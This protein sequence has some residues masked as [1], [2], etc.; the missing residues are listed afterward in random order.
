MEE[1]EMKMAS[2]PWP[3][4]KRPNID[5]VTEQLATGGDLHEE[6]SVAR[7]DV[8][9]LV[10][11]GITHIVDTRLEWSDERFVADL[12]PGISYLHLGVDDDGG[13]L[14]DW[15]FEQGTAYTRRAL[16]SPETK[17]LVHC[18]MG[19]NRGP[20]LAYAVL[21][22]EGWDAID[23]IDTIR[24]ARPIAAVDY[25]EDALDWWHR[26]ERVAVAQRE[27]DRRRL[28][29]WRRQHPIDVVRI[30]RGI[31]RQEITGSG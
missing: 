16:E 6:E 27:D 30:I 21:L 20:S 26:R 24:Q 3:P 15:W 11:A 7:S 22:V 10:D 23:A 29:V 18:H 12:A 28:A 8:A 5:F 25:A 31:R 14:P 4:I 13:V 1:S 9:A 2:E 19:V 17:V